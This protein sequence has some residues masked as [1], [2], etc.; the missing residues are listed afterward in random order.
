MTDKSSPINILIVDDTPDN[1]RLLTGILTE[2]GYKVRPATNG[3]RALSSIRKNP[4]DL[5]L[6][7]IMMPHM[8]GYEVCQ[9][10]KEDEQTRNIPVLFISALNQ[11]FDK[12]TAF[13]VGGVDYITKPFQTEE[14]LAR[15]KTHLTMRQLQQELQQKN[16]TLQDVNES[17]EEKVA[18]RTVEL[19]QANEALTTEIKQRIRHQKEKDRLF[20]V[21]SQQSEQLRN[22]TNW[23]IESQ[24][25]ERQGLASGLQEEIEQNITLLQSNL[26][27]VRTMLT[28]E[29]DQLITSHLTNAM[30]AL[31]KMND[32][33][34]HVTTNLSET[35][36]Q[37]LG[38]SENPLLKLTSREREVL[39][40]IAQGRTNTEIAA[41]LTIATATIHTYTSRI[42]RKLDIHNIPALIK[43]A[44]EHELLE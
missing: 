16:Q 9:Q 4:P 7:D 21:V 24:Q 19:G 43:F 1:L 15:V 38:L 28:D 2:Q 42:K 13:S 27:L 23:L 11:V 29:H 3:V 36:A 33:V 22:L 32:Y 8:D 18:A 25:R 20:D 10:L 31:E 34:Q 12:M 37:E 26:H 44:M 39:R 17:L 14:V 41:I 30:Q 5:I 35:S 6:L 40:F